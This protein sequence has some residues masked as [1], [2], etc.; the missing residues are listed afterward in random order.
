MPIS[1]RRHNGLADGWDQLNELQSAF[2]ATPVGSAEETEAVA[3]L[4][5]KISSVTTVVGTV[6]AH[7]ATCNPTST[8]SLLFFPTTP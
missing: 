6:R 4:D 1:G 7:L 3:Q 2:E 8:S 5:S